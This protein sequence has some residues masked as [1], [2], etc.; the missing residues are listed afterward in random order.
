MTL[1]EAFIESFKEGSTYSIG[2]TVL[3]P[4]VVRSTSLEEVSCKQEDEGRPIFCVANNLDITFDI[5]YVV[6]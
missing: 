1:H 5:I 6:S 3:C 4:K 2:S